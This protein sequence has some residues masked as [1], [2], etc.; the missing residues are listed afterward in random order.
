MS[1]NSDLKK[2]AVIC[3]ICC[4]ASSIFGAALM[5]L[6][7]PRYAIPIVV[8]QASSKLDNLK[9]A[10]RFDR[11]VLEVQG[12]Q[13][14][15]TNLIEAQAY[16]DAVVFSVDNDGDVLISGTVTIS[17]AFTLAGDIAVVNV[18]ATGYV[19]ATAA[20]TSATS[21]ASGGL[22][23]G[24]VVIASTN[25]LLADDADLT[26]ATDTLT[27]TKLG[28]FTAVGAINFD[29]QN[30]T[31]VDI[32]SGT[33]DGISSLTSSGD[34]DIG[35]HDLRAATL[36]ADGLTSGRVVFA[37]ASGVLSDDSDFTFATDTL[38]AT[39]IGAFAA[40]GAIDFDNQNM[41]NVDVDSGTIDGT[42]IGGSSAAAGTFT[43]VDAS[44]ATELD[45]GFT[46]DDTAFTVADTTGN[47]VIS[48]TLIVSDT[49]DFNSTL[50]MSNNAI[51][52]I[53][54]GGTDFSGTGGLTLA[55]AL[56][57]SSGGATISGDIDGSAEF[58]V[59]TFLNLTVQTS[60][61]VT[62]SAVFTPT[63]T[64]QLIVAAAEVTPTISTSGFTTGDQLE[65]HNTGTPVINFEA[66]G[67]QY[68]K[69]DY[70]MDQYDVLGLRWNGT[71]WV[72]LYRTG[73][74]I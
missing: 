68:L 47:T 17:D 30:M 23:S 16:T 3:A 54:A 7:H 2:I 35:A 26:F 55:D 11:L 37:G 12:W 43:T 28:A 51:S 29:S 45:G 5:M 19:S 70:P 24:R 63:G 33:V 52:N 14:Q 60:I 44:G 67:L 61:T 27:T 50:D 36:T 39:K 49:A 65:L 13:T 58:Q 34:L 1:I 74:R 48:G 42:T 20:I 38:T 9:L 72:E 31:N 56:T 40:A 71:G 8:T 18:D 62:N 21:L 59:G 69:D 32:D 64:Y 15:T 4:V 22:T 6:V 57:V 10:G 25:G 41:T 53:G 66:T 46:V 73:P